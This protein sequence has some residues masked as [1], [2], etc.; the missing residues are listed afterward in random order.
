MS[1]EIYGPDPTVLDTS[2]R[3]PHVLIVGAGLAGLT[4]ANLLHKADIP[5][6]VFEKMPETRAVG[7]ALFLAPQVLPIFQEL[8]LLDEYLAQSLPCSS[9]H[10]FNQDRQPDFQLDF[11]L[12]S[13]ITGSEGRTI[14]HSILHA[15]LLSQI[16]PERIH[17]SKRM[18]SFTQGEN[19]VLIRFS[20]SKTFEGDVLVGAD[21]PNSAVRQGLYE[22]LRRL[23]KLPSGDARASR[24]MAEDVSGAGGAGEGTGGGAQGNGKTVFLVGLTEQLE[25]DVYFPPEDVKDGTSS[26]KSTSML[27]STSTGQEKQEEE[28]HCKFFNTRSTD[29]PFSQPAGTTGLV[30]DLIARTP[31]ERMGKVVVEERM[32]ET[33]HG[34]RTVLIGDAC[35]K[36]WLLSKALSKVYSHDTT[37]NNSRANGKGE[38]GAGGAGMKMGK[39]ANLLR[40]VVGKVPAWAWKKVFERL[41]VDDVKRIKGSHNATAAAVL[42]GGVPTGAGSSRG[43]DDSGG[44]RN[45]MSNANAKRDV[46]DAEDDEE[47]AL[48]PEEQEAVE[49]A[50]TALV[51]GGGSVDEDEDEDEEDLESR[52]LLTSSTLSFSSLSLS[53]SSRN[54]ATV[55]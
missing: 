50:V 5:F 16:P 44:G 6:D 52:E 35:H 51:S 25:R 48:S 32:F 46:K 15:L 53:T 1:F 26:P 41:L 31:R 54:G 33:W 49:S 10:F 23:K 7:A 47:E 29:E 42:P 13:E 8:G 17:T 38:G 24:E 11:Q 19:G 4:L 39:G 9:I 27:T 36:A 40:R 28:E 20:D 18:L 22:Y 21:G 2:G 37:T 14:P 34:C 55:V 3:K 12:Y 43:G 45:G 30:A